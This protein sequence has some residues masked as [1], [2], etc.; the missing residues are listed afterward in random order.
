[1]FFD[2][3]NKMSFFF[4]TDLWD[5]MNRMQRQLESLASEMDYKQHPM[6]LEGSSKKGEKETKAV[7][8]FNGS[9]YSSFNPITDLAENDDSYVVSMDLPGVKKDELNVSVHDGV[10][11]VSGTRRH[12]FASDESDEEEEKKEEKK[13]DEKKEDEKKEEKVEEKEEVKKDEKNEV[14]EEKKEGEPA[15]TPAAAAAPEEKKEKK[16]KK[17]KHKVIRM[18]SYYG[19]FERSITVPVGTTC[20]DVKA[21]FED[22]VLTITIAKHK[23]DS[24]KKIEIQ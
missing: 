12:K 2:L 7:S 20:D 22:G 23:N 11:T 9:A 24:I 5:E 8:P 13:E 14:K 15:A 6:R 10:L 16:E 17:P 19:S 18:E 4:G 21:K 1:V 3:Q